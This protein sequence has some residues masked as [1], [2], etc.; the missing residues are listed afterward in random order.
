MKKFATKLMLLSTAALALLGSCDNGEK[1]SS[2]TGESEASTS[3]ADKEPSK[4]KKINEI[5]YLQEGIYLNLENFISIEYSDGSTDK[6]FELSTNSKAITIDGHKVKGT[7]VGTFYV[8]VS[9]GGLVTKLTLSVLSDDQYKMVGFF[10]ELEK[11]PRNFTVDVSYG[12][13]YF[14]TIA[15]NANY[16]VVYDPADPFAVTEEGDPDSFI[17]AKLSDGNGYKGYITR[18]ANNTPK[19]VFEPG[20]LSSYD[21]YYITMDL[22][23]DPSDSTYV[24]L[25]GDDVLLMSAT[26]TESLAYSAGVSEPSDDYGNTYPFYGA[27]FKGFQDTN[28]DGNPDEATFDIIVGDETDNVVYRTIKISKIGSTALDWMAPAITDASYIPARITADEIPAAFLA[29]NTANN[30]TLT[31]EAYSIDNNGDKTVPAEADINGEAVAWL[32]GSCDS[33][34][35]SKHTSTGIYSEKKY[36][37]LEQTAGGHSQAAEYSLADVSAVWN[38]SGAAYSTRL[39]DNED[40]TAKVLPARSAISGVTDVFQMA[41][42]KQMAANNITSAAANATNW[43]SKKTVGTKTTFAGDV[44]DDDK[45]TKKNQ[46]FE[47]LLNLFGGSEYGMITDIIG[48]GYTNAGTWWTQP[49]EFTGGDYHA[50]SLYCKY[51]S[52]SVDTSNNEVVIDISMYAPLGFDEG[53]FGMKLTLSDIGTTTFDF[54]TLTDANANPGILA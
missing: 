1:K 26:F 50:L 24:S 13:N 20:I 15:H 22:E 18:G 32:F 54:S 10:K 3:V 4:I 12:T 30:F 37:K 41:E 34:I 51:T 52:L 5:P 48:G 11:D 53:T 36:K 46:L 43:T 8:T 6:E 7:E 49:E 9:A 42:V 23:L 40:Q 44:G 28:I 33:V 19:P 35:T 27:A 21:W 16:S 39:T 17:L 38:D 31:L 14:W 29:A 45:T 25:D 47:Q 2:A